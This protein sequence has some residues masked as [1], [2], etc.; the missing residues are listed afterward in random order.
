VF[1]VRPIPESGRVEALLAHARARGVRVD[2]DLVPTMLTR[3]PRDMRT[4]VA[5]LDALDAFALE[6]G[7]ALTVPLLREWLLRTPVE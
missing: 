6:R 4:L 2:D 7:R 5:A 3:L 1:Q